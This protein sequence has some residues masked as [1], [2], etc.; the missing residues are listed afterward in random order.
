MTVRQRVEDKFQGLL[1][2]ASDAMMIVDKQGKITLVNAQGEK[3][4]GYSR[5]ELI[6]QSVDFLIPE[7]YR[8]QYSR[9][10]EH[11]FADPQVS[12][13]G[14]GVELFGLR[15]DGSEFPAE[16]SLS[17]FTS[18]DE[19]FA[20]SAIRDVSERKLAENQIRKLNDDLEQALRRS[21]KLSATLRRVFDIKGYSY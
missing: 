4:F 5:S 2:A 17:S 21:D 13:M 14:V 15:K 16:I 6:G 10:R 18:E 9:H 7:R 12:P 8:G 19:T 11:F 1:E 3:L 20:I